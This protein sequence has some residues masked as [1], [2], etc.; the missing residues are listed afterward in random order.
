MNT[1]GH[2]AEGCR[3]NLFVIKGHTVFTPGVR[4][5][6]LPGVVR[7]LALTA[8][9]ALGFAVHETRVLAPAKCAVG[10]STIFCAS[11]TH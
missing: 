9:R 3:S 11:T 7:G 10:C 2:L 1:R 6:I 5:G 8:S 4:D